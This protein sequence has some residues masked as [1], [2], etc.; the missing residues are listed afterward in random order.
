[1]SRI[2]IKYTEPLQG[3]INPPPDKSISHRAIIT[4]SLA[5]GESIIRNFLHAEDP[6]RTLEAFRR[7]GTAIEV[8]DGEV[9]IRGKGLKGLVQPQEV[10]DCGNSGTTMR[11]LSGVLAGQPF[12]TTLTGDSSLQHR[13]MQRVILPLEE[14]GATIISERDGYPPL[15]ISGGELRPISY[16][17]PVASA[18]VKSAILFAGL[19]CDGITTVTEPEKSRDHTERMLKANGA[20]IEVQ[21]LEVQ[22]HGRGVL[23]PLDVTVPGDFSSAAFFIVAGLLI[24]GSE[25]TIRNTGINPTRTGL[26]DILKKMGADIALENKREVSGEPVADISVKHSYLSGIEIGG[27][28]VLRSIDEFPVLCVA[29]AC[30]KGVT[31][32]TGARELRVKESDRIASMASELGKM[33]IDTEDYE[34]GIIISGKERFRNA[35]V[36]SHKDHRIAMAMVIAGLLADGVTT[37]EDTDCIETSFPGFM[38][39]IESLM[40]E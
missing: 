11:I 16:R 21:G 36:Q 10:I 26:I 2:S 6:I 40:R 17:S 7:M 35:T 13:P 32:I 38:E 19:Y 23:S 9:I 3:E 4:A 1:M 31:K 28:M 12:S 30:A 18:Q 37:I 8:R 5:E 25:V 24:P 29:A 15:T 14:M 33:G 20:S 34:D 22:I 39:R 27:T